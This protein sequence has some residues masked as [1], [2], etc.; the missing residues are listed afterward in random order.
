MW[1]TCI[2]ALRRPCTGGSNTHPVLRAPSLHCSDICPVVWFVHIHADCCVGALISSSPVHFSGCHQVGDRWTITF[3]MSSISTSELVLLAELQIKLPAFSASKRAVVDLYHSHKQSCDPGRASCQEEEEE[4]FLGSFGATPSSTASSLKVFNVT[5]RLK[6]WLHK[7]RD[8][9][10]HEASGEPDAKDGEGSGAQGNTFSF[11]NLIA[12][13]RK[14]NHPITN[15]VMMVIFSKHNQLQEGPAA[16]SLI[17]TVEN[18]KYVM[19]T[20]VRGDGQSR[21]HKRNRI[22]R[23]RA[24]GG[25]EPTAAPAA[26]R[27]QRSLCRRVDMWVDFDHIGWNEWIVHPKRYNAYRCE[28]E[29]PSPLDESF[30]PT[31]HAYMQVRWQPLS[32]QRSACFCFHWIIVSFSEPPATPSPRQSLLSVL[33]AHPPQPPLHA[34]LRERWFDPAASRGD[35]CWRVWLPIKL[36]IRLIVFY[37]LY[38][39]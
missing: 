27:V 14:V 33:R 2:L 21:R 18:S 28:G 12:E 20:R 11:N 25:A 9:L 17:H 3:D 19:A 29:C 37:F 10:S 30:S 36:P 13:Q 8:A 23:M 24:A 4:V 35:D 22:E 15:R 38:A 7:R 5:E 32:A 26:E 31:N 16:Y 1:G 34:L 39:Y 6:Y